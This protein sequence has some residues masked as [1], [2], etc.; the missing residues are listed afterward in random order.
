MVVLSV[1][2]GF[3]VEEIL[4]ASLAIGEEDRD[5]IA[6]KIATKESLSESLVHTQRKEKKLTLKCGVAQL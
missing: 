2:N 6:N 3:E 1:G 5:L 4:Q